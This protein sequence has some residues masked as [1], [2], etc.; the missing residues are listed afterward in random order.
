MLLKKENTV[1]KKKKLFAQVS[2]I[3]TSKI[4]KGNPNLCFI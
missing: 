3:V 2:H 4:L 1:K